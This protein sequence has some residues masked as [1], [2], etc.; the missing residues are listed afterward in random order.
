MHR[1]AVSPE[2][3]QVIERS[4]QLFDQQPRF[5]AAAGKRDQAELP[6]VPLEVVNK[7]EG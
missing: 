5:G 3:L 1:G 6:P 4:D 7:R 2:Q